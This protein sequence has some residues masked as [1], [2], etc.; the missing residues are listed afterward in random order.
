MRL[1]PAM[2]AGLALAAPLAAHAQ[3]PE[4]L[5]QIEPGAGEWQAEYF[6]ALGRGGDGSHAFEAMLGVGERFAI[7]V[8]VEARYAHG[9]IAFETI[10]P[11]L[12]YRFTGEDAPV[13]VGL[14]LQV[15]FD[16]DAAP[17]EAEARL[18][19]AAQSEAW[20]AQ[21][22]VMLRRSSD[23]GAAAGSLA[24]A[25]SLQ[26]RLGRSAWLGLEASGQSAP[27]WRDPGATD[28]HGRFAGPSLTF[29]W[30]P[31]RGPGIELGLAWLRRIGGDG[32]ADSA[33]FF[34]QLTF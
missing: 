27:L 1:L 21:G 20:W 16:R 6:A 26:H 8:E 13:G 31:A 24:Y 19:V 14:Q 9:A 34:V 4:Q 15:G 23:A 7:G 18:I 28:E 2:L 32:P 22:N 3:G 17:V 33:R 5:D 12:L 11:K 25:A 29:D 10:G 30:E